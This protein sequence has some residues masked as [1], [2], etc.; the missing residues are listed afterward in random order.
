MDEQDIQDRCRYRKGV[1]DQYRSNPIQ[2]SGLSGL[3]MFESVSPFSGCA[4]S[5]ALFQIVR[6]QINGRGDDQ[7]F[8]RN[9]Q[10]VDQFVGDARRG[11]QGAAGPHRPQFRAQD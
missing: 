10:L 7:Q 5:P 8:H 3:S 4:D 2:K 9:P 1:D 6:F 11:E